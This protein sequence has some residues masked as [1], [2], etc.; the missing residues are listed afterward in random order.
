[1]RLFARLYHDLDTTTRT[2]EKTAALERYFREAPARDAAW[3]L[4]LLSGRR[5]KRAVSGPMLFR[6]ATEV[7][8]L[9]EWLVGEC[10]SAVGDGSETIALLLPPPAQAVEPPPLHRLIEERIVP[11]AKLDEEGKKAVVLRTWS[12][13]EA[14]ERF[15]F[16][17]LLSGTYRVGAAAKLVARA[18]AN[19]VG[20]DPAVMAHRLTGDWKPTPDDETSFR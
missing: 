16:H 2:S 12:E 8:G 13:L 19:V 14:R 3:A 11:L 20:V 10:Y 17:K 6:W 15:L 9:P 18:L 5:M 4:W 7:T 1:M